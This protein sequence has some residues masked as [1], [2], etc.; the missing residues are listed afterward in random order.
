MSVFQKVVEA[1]RKG[2]WLA[3]WNSETHSLLGRSHRMEIKMGEG[4]SS[5]G[6]SMSHFKRHTTGLDFFLSFFINGKKEK[7]KINQDDQ[8]SPAKVNQKRAT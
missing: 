8:V 2:S 4:S 1:V 5:Q 7:D 6:K 3:S